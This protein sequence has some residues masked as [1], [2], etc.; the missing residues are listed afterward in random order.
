MILLTPLKEF[1]YERLELSAHLANEYYAA[2]IN[3]SLIQSDHRHFRTTLK[4]KRGNSKAP[5]HPVILLRSVHLP[6]M[7]FLSGAQTEAFLRGEIV[8]VSTNSDIA[9]RQ[10]DYIDDW[11]WRL[12]FSRFGV[13]LP[14]RAD[15]FFGPQDQKV[16]ALLGLTQ[17]LV[18]DKKFDSDLYDA[19][20]ISNN[21][22]QVIVVL[23]IGI[24]NLLPPLIRLVRINA[25]KIIY[26]I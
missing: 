10:L 17:K 19:F 15:D 5:K 24:L 16:R 7:K 25:T 22:N 12:K 3:F 23:D 11:A 21:K 2:K 26:Y 18:L 4:N 13:I 6:W 9:Y 14:D 1:I 8:D 20:V